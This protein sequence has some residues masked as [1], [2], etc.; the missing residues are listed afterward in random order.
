MN[1]RKTR[2]KEYVEKEEDI[3]TRK[4]GIKK[5]KEIRKNGE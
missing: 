5:G 4:K 1:F 3:A 2:E